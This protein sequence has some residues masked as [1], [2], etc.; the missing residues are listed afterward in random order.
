[1]DEYD[2]GVKMVEGKIIPQSA[3]NTW[4][5]SEYD[6]GVIRETRITTEP[7]DEYGD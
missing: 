7:Y 5:E 1:M 4:D 3:V 2:F 6:R